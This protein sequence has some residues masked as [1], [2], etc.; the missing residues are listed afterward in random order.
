MHA[1][2]SMCTGLRACPATQ[3]CPPGNPMGPHA[4]LTYLLKA[5]LAGGAKTY[6]LLAAR[7]EVEH[8]TETLQALRF[9]EACAQVEV[10]AHKSTGAERA[11][12]AA[13]A[14]IDGQI[15]S[16]EAAIR[17]KERFET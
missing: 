16:L 15:A 9:G 13:L 4:Q 6:V 3:E 10:A 17:A 5:S 11:A 1:H 7:P 8:A 2:T 14:A 12:A